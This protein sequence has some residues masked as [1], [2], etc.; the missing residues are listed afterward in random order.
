MML[1]IHPWAVRANGLIRGERIFESNDLTGAEL[2]NHAVNR[3]NWHYVAGKK[4]HT[5]NQRV[6]RAIEAGDYKLLA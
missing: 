1:V 6:K 3:S 5:V 4:V 2:I